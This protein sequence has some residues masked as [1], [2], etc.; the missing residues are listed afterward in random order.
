MKTLLA[1]MMLA[2]CAIA[3]GQEVPDNPNVDPRIEFFPLRITARIVDESGKPIEGAT[4]DVGI[5]N[6]RYK[7]QLN[8][9]VG[10]SDSD[11]KFTAESLAVAA[12]VQFVVSKDGYYIS[13][14]LFEGMENDPEKVRPVGRFEPWNP[15]VNIVLKKIGK[16]IPMLVRMD[17]R[18]DMPDVGRTFQFDLMAWDWLPPHGKGTVADLLIQVDEQKEGN[19]VQSSSIKLRFNNKH[20][21]MIPIMELHG[22]ESVLKSPR[23]APEA[24]YDMREFVRAHQK[25]DIFT[26]E[27]LEKIPKGY[28]LRIRTKVNKAGEV[29]S[30]YYGKIVQ[31]NLTRGG[32]PPIAYNPNGWHK[33]AFRFDS[34]Y[35]NPTPNDRNLEYDQRNNL[36]PGIEPGYQWPP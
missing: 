4:V 20:D 26:Y 15:T 2:L 10:K 28:F 22:V 34:C 9:I 3:C 8:N 5:G 16:P 18:V 19:E 12:Y 7:D 32:F 30:A 35:I 23:T 21:G 17:D 36:A 6:L 31:T 11:G 1:I 24:G 27:E 13:R 33:A 29:V 25:G 14:M